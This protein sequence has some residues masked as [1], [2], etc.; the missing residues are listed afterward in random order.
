MAIIRTSIRTCLILIFAGT[1][2][3]V[4]FKLTP[5]VSWRAGKAVVHAAVNGDQATPGSEYAL[6]QLVA[7]LQ[8]DRPLLVPMDGRLAASIERSLQRDRSIL[9]SLGPLQ[10]VLYLGSRSESDVYRTSFRNGSLTWHLLL[11]R[12][13][14][15]KLWFTAP[16]GPLPQDWINWYALLPPDNGI[17]RFIFG[18]V[19]LSVV[20]ALGLV[21]GLRL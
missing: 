21:V 12:G 3:A 13:V 5:A 7:D 17:S 18:L 9:K 19:K 15:E 11:R 8:Q 6:R 1:I 2:I 10:S 16:E 4:T 20:T 14:L